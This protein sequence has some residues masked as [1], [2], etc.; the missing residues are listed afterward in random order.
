MTQIINGVVTGTATGDAIDLTDYLQSPA[1]MGTSMF[2][3]GK[4]G[5]DT[6]TGTPLH[7]YMAGGD[8]DDVLIGGAGNNNI[9]GDA[10]NDTLSAAG[11]EG[12]YSWLY[13]DDGD[14]SITAGAG[15]DVLFGGVGND[16]IRGGLGANK[17]YGEAGDD[18]LSGGIG[19]DTIDGGAGNDRILLTGEHDNA[20][21]NQTGG[22]TSLYAGVVTGEGDMYAGGTGLDLLEADEA[23]LTLVING[24]GQLSADG[25]E[26]ISS[27]TATG[28]R[29]WVEGA[30]PQDFTTV[31]LDTVALHFGEGDDTVTGSSASQ[32]VNADGDGL[33]NDNNGASGNDSLFGGAGTDTAIFA[34]NRADYLVS[35]LANK[36]M[37][38]VD[39]NTA[40]GNTGLDVL[41]GFE[42]LQFA[43]LTLDLT[44]TNWQDSDAAGGQTIGG[45][46]GLVN[47]NTSNGATVGVD[48]SADPAVLLAGEAVSYSLADNAGGRFAIHA[49][50]GVV[51]IAEA[52]LID[53]E[54]APL[55]G[56]GPERGYTISIIATTLELSS[57][58]DVT[59]VIADGNEAPD[60]LADSDLGTADEVI[61][62][63]AT[64][65]YVGI[66]AAGT[67]PNGDAMT[68]SLVDNA[69]GRFSI[70]TFTGR[71]L[72]ANGALLDYEGQASWII[73][74]RA[75]DATMGFDQS[76][77]IALSDFAGDVPVD[78][79]LATSDQIIEGAA[80]GT[81]TGVTASATSPHGGT[82]VYSLVDDA[83]GRF[84]ID[85]VNGQIS[86][87]DGT[88]LD[89]ETVPIWYV[90]VRATDGSAFNDQLFAIAL[91]DF[92]GETP[93]DSDTATAD[94]VIEG[95][96]A[97]TY[98]G[99]TAS[100]LS[101]WG[102]TVTYALTDTAGGRF[103]IDASSGRVSVANGALLDFEAKGF[104]YIGVSA[105][106]GK[107]TSSDIFAIYV[108]DSASDTPVDADASTPDEV[109][110]GAATG[111]YTGLTVQALSPHGGTMV[112]SLLSDADGRFAIDAA[113][114][115]VTVAN[116]T[117]LDFENQASWQITVRASDGT[118]PI[119]ETF[120]IALRDFAGE[121][122]V[123][124][125]PGAPDRVA[126]NAATGTYA[127]LTALSVSASELPMTY[128][129]VDDAGGLFAIDASS[130]VVSVQ[131]ASMLTNPVS[132]TVDITI[133][134]TDGS[135][136][137]LAT[138][139]MILQNTIPQI[140][141]GTG[142]ADTQTVTGY[143]YWILSGLDGADT[144][145]AAGGND[146]VLG[147]AGH[148]VLS[149]GAGLDKIE[150]GA[151]NDS[152]A[153]GEGAD[154]LSGQD[155]NDTVFGEAGSD[156][157]GGH[158]GDDWLWGG[159]GHDI[160]WGDAGADNVEGEGGN[161]TLFG[162][163]GH[164]T[165]TGGEGNDLLSG[166]EENDILAGLAGQDTLIGG[167]G[168][169][170][171]GGHEGD[172]RLW[173]G[174]GD[175]IAWGDD[176][177]DQ[178]GGHEGQDTLFGGAGSDTIWGDSGNDLL[179]GGPDSDEISGGLGL[180]TLVGDDGN[181]RLFGNEDNDNLAGLAGND[182][183]NGDAGD[184]TLGGHEGDDRLWGG[185]G[186]DIAWGDAGADH[187]GGHEGQDTLFGGDGPDLIWGDGDDDQLWG[188][189]E[190]DT[191]EGGA[192]NDA[193]AGEAGQDVFIYFANAGVDSI[194]G[195]EGGA[196][197]GDVIRILGQPAFDSFAEVEVAATVDAG[198][199]TLNLTGTSI[200]LIGLTGFT[201]L[202]PDD[203]LFL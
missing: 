136:P 96:A 161:D 106:D 41:S 14:D 67:D 18:R 199:L 42:R 146:T 59:I 131:D 71:V 62:G 31:R 25:I 183:L 153:G 116:G 4:A 1:N 172:D 33:F 158:D 185:A 119:D 108:T 38:V 176:G 184:D 16:T 195:F 26:G 189:S 39:T 9:H 68:Y 196:G 55:L 175:D 130:G 102:G 191:L 111:T 101:A 179:V 115:Q 152:L 151:G 163:F 19:R 15:L 58:R 160:A 51:S 91:S 12:S 156:V 121:A 162:G 88:R 173:G 137:H 34:G 122:L 89:Y 147:G 182:T 70:E 187:L 144:L 79:D 107:A 61:E 145:V 17:L 45:L 127:G 164:D 56:S 27:G 7:D 77:T 90:N 35:L 78:S 194:T 201:Q 135:T 44:P 11:V 149:G 94:E 2:S 150:G 165:L 95:A 75:S 46:A 98:T 123:D 141:T 109:M 81:Y 143:A 124:A 20:T 120:T 80:T 97:G 3:D 57:R 159:E 48:I 200:R 69:G 21:Y 114:G 50:T 126:L 105:S 76:F 8:G 43:D 181:D 138:F 140:W 155:G 63:A 13:G 6:I 72:V 73:T 132:E 74:I 82:M 36:T 40:D 53:Y 24:A 113:S 142:V 30:G 104:W 203:F 180:D 129:L 110:E 93:S 198:V 28:F 37:L 174:M 128:S 10:G 92:M 103:A 178:L 167:S 66:T 148:D 112:Y 202:N 170:T 190:N 47:E 99:F 22:K 84:A 29:V 166:D 171:L 60:T 86:V 118:T 192:G 64:G 83:G 186:R 169:D 32:L 133:S 54:T 52:G 139:T 100:A 193:L 177:A 157:I 125:N 168:Q 5:N 154:D 87:A 85:A 197:A 117:Q 65:T 23:N 49:T 188:G 134:A